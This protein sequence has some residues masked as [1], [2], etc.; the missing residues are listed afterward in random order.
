M[1]LSNIII[2]SRIL[3][4]Y[5][6]LLSQTY[7]FGHCMYVLREIKKNKNKPFNSKLIRKVLKKQKAKKIV[8]AVPYGEFKDQRANLPQMYLL[9]CL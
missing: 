5:I 2:K 9:Q 7:P 8:Q 4:M 6:S 1:T 3:K